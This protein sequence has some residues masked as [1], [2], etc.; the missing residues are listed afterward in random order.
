M[1]NVTYEPEAYGPTAAADMIVCEKAMRV[2]QAAFPNHP[3]LIGADHGAGTVHI[4][5]QYQGHNVTNSGYGFLLHMSSIMGADCEKKLRTA[6]GEIL[7]RFKLAR[8][9]ATEQSAARAL[10][11]GLD[12]S[13]MVKA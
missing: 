8:D 5:L 7:E 6:A 12:L 2:L 1:S 3:W 10:Q 9:G 11:N 13:C 4:R